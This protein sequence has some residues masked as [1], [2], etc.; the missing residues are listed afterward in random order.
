MKLL[1]ILKPSD[2]TDLSHSES[3]RLEVRFE[4][5]AQGTEFRHT[6]LL[7]LGLETL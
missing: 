5:I 4:A 1:K 3:A 6:G 2:L 7:L